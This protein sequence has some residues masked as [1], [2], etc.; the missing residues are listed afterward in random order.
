MYIRYTSLY[1]VCVFLVSF[2]HL[3][4]W[5]VLYYCIIFHWFYFW[6]CLWAYNKDWL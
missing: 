3:C 4:I 6:F 1:D 5:C 2:Y